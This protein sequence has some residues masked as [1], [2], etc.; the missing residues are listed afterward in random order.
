MGNECKSSVSEDAVC[1]AEGALI[2]SK[3]ST[4][5]TA[6]HPSSSSPSCKDGVS[7]GQH[8]NLW[9]KAKELFGCGGSRPVEPQMSSSGDNRLKVRVRLPNITLPCPEDGIYVPSDK[10][11]SVV[12]SYALDWTRTEFEWGWV[13]Q[14]PDG[15][16][17]VFAKADG[18][19]EGCIDVSDGHSGVSYIFQVTV[20][21]D[22]RSLWVEKD[23]PPT[24]PYPKPHVETLA[25]E[26]FGIKVFGASRRGR[27]HGQNGTFRDDD[28]GIWTDKENT[29]CLLAVADGAGSAKYS[30]QGSKKAI[31][32][33]VDCVSKT[34]KPENWDG[35]LTSTGAVARLLLRAS[36]DAYNFL[37]TY[38]KDAAERTPSENITVKDFN[39]TLL[40]ALL[41]RT[42]DGGLKMVTFSIGDGAIAWYSEKGVDLMCAPD[43]GEYSG[44]T[45]FLT[46]GSVWHQASK[47]YS[48]FMKERVFVREV[49]AR[50][51]QDGH[52][53]L[54]TDGVSDPFFETDTTLTDVD[55]W[56]N[57]VENELCGKAHLNPYE[58]AQTN[59]DRLLDWLLFWSKG[60]HDDRTLVVVK[61][62]ALDDVK[63][64]GSEALVA[65]DAAIM[66]SNAEA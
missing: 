48:A 35:E 40:L 18:E 15:G 14:C 8:L 46:T 41:K 21:P 30:R 34:I 32:A 55:L 52:L 53:L 12:G 28:M 54:M 58:S 22:P 9:G 45:R 3:E 47:D 24:A 17:R 13:A 5:K 50:E 11:M 57:L 56:R 60:N 20:N 4:E 61:P 43:G 59:A 64:S 29:M 7:D 38:A 36:Y 65:N 10:V 39:T 62:L 44:Q 2:E 27:S 66:N 31:A 63:D 49:D 33:V 1:L 23:P 42:D 37:V 6:T 16:F 26:A 51:A 19:H 25:Y